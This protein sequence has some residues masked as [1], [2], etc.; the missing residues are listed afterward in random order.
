MHQIIIN[1]I[2]D[3]T[4][5]RTLKASLIKNHNGCLILTSDT[6]LNMKMES[7][8]SNS[9]EA[10]TFLKISIPHLHLAVTLC[11]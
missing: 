1:T 9:R 8:K 7:L 4:C 6:E 2:H 10:K 3:L 11:Y 5:Y